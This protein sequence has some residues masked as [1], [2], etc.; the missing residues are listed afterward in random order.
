[1]TD[2]ESG[3]RTRQAY[4]EQDIAE[5]KADVHRLADSYQAMAVQLAALGSQYASVVALKEVMA[6]ITTLEAER[7]RQAGGAQWVQY[8]IF[9]LFTVLNLIIAAQGKLWS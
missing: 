6:R 1:M 7:Q 8:G 9:V 3:L 5:L 2:Q 4:L